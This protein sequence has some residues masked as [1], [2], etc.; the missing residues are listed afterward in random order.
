[1]AM[2]AILMGSVLGFFGAL[3]AWLFL[4]VTVMSA[5]SLYF[6][7]ALG[8]GLLPVLSCALRSSLRAS[9]VTAGV[10]H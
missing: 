8:F 3:V 7:T 5:V 4:D 6:A 10:A 1:M 2:M 9:R